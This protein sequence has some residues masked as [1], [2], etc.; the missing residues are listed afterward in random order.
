LGRNL[1]HSYVISRSGS[2]FSDADLA[3]AGQIQRFVIGLDRQ[4]AV[5]RRLTACDRDRGVE[6]GLTA[7]EL[8]VLSLL[9]RGLSSQQIARRLRCSPRTVQKH[10]E[11]VYRKL[12]VRDR[13]NALRIAQQWN[14]MTTPGRPGIQ[15]TWGAA[16][17]S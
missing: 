11:H 14:L 12:G 15:T 13:V 5:T 4:I 9:T 16:P 17:D 7:R 1:Y 3:M 6:A 10:L 8:C 2:D